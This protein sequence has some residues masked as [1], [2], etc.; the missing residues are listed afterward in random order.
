MRKLKLV[1]ASEVEE[2]SKHYIITFL[3]S[4]DFGLFYIRYRKPRGIK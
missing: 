4:A 2:I 1:T 3:A